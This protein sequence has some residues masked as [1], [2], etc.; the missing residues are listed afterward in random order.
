MS[1]ISDADPETTRIGPATALAGKPFFT[2]MSRVVYRAKLLAGI[3]AS[4][5]DEA[6]CTRAGLI[7]L[8]GARLYAACGAVNTYDGAGLT[9]GAPIV[10]VEE[11]A[12]ANGHAGRDLRDGS[13]F[14]AAWHIARGN[15]CGSAIAIGG[16]S[17]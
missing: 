2:T 14:E 15:W 11:G 10:V 16:A 9:F 4:G 6:S 8:A 7:G 1:S 17:F 12:G 13:C 5:A 3:L